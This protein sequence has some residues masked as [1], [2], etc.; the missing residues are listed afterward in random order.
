MNVVVNGEARDVR[1]GATVADLVEE[2]GFTGRNVVVERNGE[3]VKRSRFAHVGL[4]SGD[5]VEVVRPVQGGSGGR[6][7]AERRRPQ[8]NKR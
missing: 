7:R 1:T 2:L 8:G 5:V 6:Q 4:A 3:P